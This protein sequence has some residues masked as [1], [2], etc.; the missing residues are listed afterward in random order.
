MPRAPVQHRAAPKAAK[1]HGHDQRRGTAA[2]RGYDGRWRKARRL[3]LQEH[4]LCAHCENEGIIR[5]ATVVDHVIPHRGDAALF[6]DVSN[7]QP[8]CKVHHDRKTARGQ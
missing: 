3:F 8:L 2:S 1:T 7:W 6:W 4:P 5:P